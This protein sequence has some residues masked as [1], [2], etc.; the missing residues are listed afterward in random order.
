[1]WYQCRMEA[2]MKKVLLVDDD[3]LFSEFVTAT[4]K[5][6]GAVCHTINDG[7]K[8]SDI[9]LAQFDHVLLDLN[10]PG[11]D[12][13]QVL[14]YLKEQAFSAE[15]SILSGSDI[16]I[17][18]SAK[19]VAKGYGLRIRSVLQKPFS[20]DQLVS[21]VS[22]STDP[23]DFPVPFNNGH[24]SPDNG[25]NEV[26]Y[27]ALKSA[28]SRREIDVFFQPKVNL[29]DGRLIGFE[30]LARWTHNGTFIA[31]DVFI[32]VAE[33]HALINDLTKLVV[34]KGFDAFTDY[35]GICH[36]L[37]LSINI[38]AK[39][40][41]DKVL[42]DYLANQCRLFGLH[43]E[44]IILELTET[45]LVSDDMD[46]LQVL[47]RL[48]I[49]GFGLSID[50]F[51][52]GY[53]SISQL[54]KIPFTELKIDRSFIIK[55]VEEHQS[56][57]IVNSTINMANRLGLDI[58]A[59]GIEDNETVLALVE[60]GC[61]YGQGYHYARPMGQQQ[62][63]RWLQELPANKRPISEHDPYAVTLFVVTDNAINAQRNIEHLALVDVS[64]FTPDSIVEVLSEQS[65]PSVII[66]DETTLHCDA[67]KL[68]CELKAQDSD[69]III[70]LCQNV[71]VHEL[72][73]ASDANIDDIVALPVDAGE[74][75]AK[76]RRVIR[77]RSS[78]CTP[79]VVQTQQ[80]QDICDSDLE[81][82]L[83]SLISQFS[84]VKQLEQLVS[85]MYN[86]LK[87]LGNTV[88]LCFYKTEPMICFSDNGALSNETE[89]QVFEL[90]KDKIGVT[91]L[92]NAVVFN[93]GSCSIMVKDL[94]HPERD[95]N[96]KK[97]QF[98]HYLAY[99]IEAEINLRDT[100]TFQKQDKLTEGVINHSF[101]T[102]HKSF[103][104][105]MALQ[106]MSQASDAVA[107]SNEESLSVSRRPTDLE[108]LNLLHSL[109]R[110]LTSAL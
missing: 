82:I 64:Y 19:Q 46:S 96:E 53:S 62:L 42:P 81:A 40:L 91:R 6:K 26:I 41:S 30:Q 7:K 31:P 102:L 65:S 104:N 76:Y 29:K 68:S 94:Q 78:R 80:K 22:S 5:I 4:L 95:W 97:Q 27:E 67:F 54:Q 100:V 13:L 90:L 99:A 93:Q 61:F 45:S 74:L 48:R 75:I 44:Q 38:S 11:L 55:F 10:I 52:T 63:T 47:T 21:A 51:G 70:L 56:Q 92:G 58:V 109:V 20:V 49:M 73:H 89:H 35:C 14:R 108:N 37:N 9:E 32:A 1:M 110:R 69:V 28:I 71:S 88:S 17:L 43:P 98:F 85:T 79:K 24:V 87:E 72:T 83:A 77:H 8:I 12:G 23:L 18:N 101:D 36:G 103:F 25:D 86:Q 3:A 107:T 33:Q 66:I 106:S 2:C 59:E 60:N 16:S 84:V 34:E 15:V 105:Y 57:A 39:S 50:D